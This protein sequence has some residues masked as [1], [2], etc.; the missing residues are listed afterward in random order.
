MDIS[1]APADVN[2]ALG[3]LAKEAI[4]YER[5]GTQVHC[6]VEEKP[7]DE[8]FPDAGDINVTLPGVY[9][10]SARHVNVAETEGKAEPHG[11]IHRE[12]QRQARLHGI[13]Y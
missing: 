6:I 4:Q 9:E 2:K 8:G 1:V 13:I 10:D 5:I 7:P 3:S 11:L 12:I